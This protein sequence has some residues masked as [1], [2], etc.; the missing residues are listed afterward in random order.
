MVAH[1]HPK[2]HPLLTPVGTRHVWGSHTCK[3]TKEDLFTLVDECLHVF[4]SVVVGSP[5]IGVTDGCEPPYGVLGPLLEANSFPL[6]DQ[7]VLLT[8]EPSLAPVVLKQT[9][10]GFSTTAFPPVSLL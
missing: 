5:H 9:A 4:M 7:E 3:Q 2:Q 10:S 1:N 8:I 6:P